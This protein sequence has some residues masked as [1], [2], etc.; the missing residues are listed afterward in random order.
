MGFYLFSF[1]LDHLNASEF[2]NYLWL[3]DG[4]CWGC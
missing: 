2:W 3:I 1:V 4:T